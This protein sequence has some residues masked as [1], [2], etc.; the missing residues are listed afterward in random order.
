MEISESDGFGV[1]AIEMRCFQS[2][3]S[4]SREIAI[5]LVIGEND[6]H[7]RPAHTRLGG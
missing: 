1:Q 5:T 3:V 4:V 6:D 2:L 7:I